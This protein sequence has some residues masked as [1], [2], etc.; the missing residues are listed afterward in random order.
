MKVIAIKSNTRLIKGQVYEVDAFTGK[1]KWV[2]PLQGDLLA[3]VGGRIW[4]YDQ[5]NRLTALS[6]PTADQWHF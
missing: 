3:V 5:L 1:R 6:L 4:C 2:A